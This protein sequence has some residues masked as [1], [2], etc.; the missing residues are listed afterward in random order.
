MSDSSP[1]PLSD[2]IA[3]IGMACLL[4]GS[5]GPGQFWRHVF[6]KKGFIQDAPPEWIGRR[7][8]EGSKDLDRIY[9]KRV[10]LLGDLAAFDPVAYGVVPNAIP[11]SEP[12]HFLA[13]RLAAEALADAGYA[14]RPFDRENT[15]VILGRGA[16]PNRGTITGQ[17]AGQGV[18]LTTDLIAKL[19]PELDAAIL[20]KIRRSLIESLPPLP[21]EASP[22][23]VSN[24]A[25]GRIANRLDL[26][27]PSY[28]I[29]AACASS[30][31]AVEQAMKELRSGSSRMML[32][33]GVQASMP[34][35]VYML[36]CQLQA[37]SRESAKPFDI[38]AD[39]TILAEGVGFLV[40][41]RLADAEADGDTIYAVLR[42]AGLASDGRAQGLLTPRLEGEILA[43]RRAYERNGLAPASVGLIEAHGTGIAL[44]DRTEL[45]ALRAAFPPSANGFP[46]VAIGSVKS[47][48]GHCIPAAGIAS[49]IK[50]ALALRF[51]ILPPTLCGTV[52]PEFHEPD[53]PF[54][55]NTE[56]RPWIHADRSQPRRAGVNAFGFGGINAHLVLEEYTG[57]GADEDSG[58]V[59]PTELLLFSAETPEALV[60]R[61]ESVSA[62]VASRPEVELA[63]VAR[64][65]AEEPMGRCRLAFQARDLADFREQATQALGKLAAAKKPRGQTRDG[66]VFDL[67]TPTEPEGGTAF[68][69]PGQGS[70]YAGM[71]AELCMAFPMVRREFDL[72]D[73]AY[74]GL[75]PI[76]PSQCVYPPPTGLGEE[77]AA[78]LDR[79]FHRI[80]AGLETIFTANYAMFKLLERFGVGC[81][82]MVGHSTGEYSA[83]AAAGVVALPDASGQVVL[84]QELNRFFYAMNTPEKVAKGAL[85]TVGNISEG[86]LQEALAGAKGEVH[87]AMDNCPSQKILFGSPT[88]IETLRERFQAEGGLCQVLPFGHAYHT[89]LLDRLREELTTFYEKIS[90]QKPAHRVVSCATFEDFPDLPEAARA[91][92][93]Q[94]WM[95]PVRFQETV[96]RLF[97]EGVRHF[98]EVG[99]NDHLTAFVEDTLRRRGALALATNAPGV[100]ATTH[101]QR[102]LARLWCRGFPVRFDPL[103][104]HRPV[105]AVDPFAPDPKPGTPQR[106][107]RLDLSI[108]VMSLSD[109]VVAEVRAQL[110]APPPP[111]ETAAPP[112]A[113]SASSSEPTG[114]RPPAD[115][116]AAVAL[117]HQELMQEF[118]ASQQRTLEALASSLGRPKS[119]H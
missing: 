111:A 6:E 63:A 113:P 5:A 105:K 69:F 93:V 8:E 9:T 67:E 47:M 76:L 24:V 83:L 29:D 81:D 100:P 22:G 7:L 12:D 87:I 84:K 65:L 64:W 101:W 51:K 45:Q 117:A 26:Q 70:Q 72:S 59:W 115:S 42:G 10:G 97:E 80:D 114:S 112:A 73:A 38:G 68:L 108:P 61:I 85:L 15:G 58:Y 78:E 3:I 86:S 88:A 95:A 18:D 27:G 106:G 104:Q 89:P 118:L 109:S 49:L 98:I 110:A 92:A 39:G 62:A 46:S 34:P 75:W 1:P 30:L 31:I 43:I 53:N 50:T 119:D 4:P 23:L 17:L 41:K 79:Q 94:Q 77:R 82:V 16:T 33:G 54:Y 107:K 60:A 40:L 102:T 55:V 37:L 66:L 25:V 99:P 57:A 35:Q 90:F 28:M 103:Y 20:E 14:D 74:R 56:P 19:L 96:R 52:R 71:L 116:A 91:L 13:L 44:G 36:F 11:G 32:A 48:I 2:A 21:P